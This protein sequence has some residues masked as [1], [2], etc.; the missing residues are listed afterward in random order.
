MSV[1]FS[2]KPVQE[3]VPI[4][5]GSNKPFFKNTL[6]IPGS[7]IYQKDLPSRR[8]YGA[9]RTDIDFSRSKVPEDRINF[10]KQQGLTK[11]QRFAMEFYEGKAH[12]EKLKA[13]A[14]NLSIGSQPGHHGQ[15][16]SSVGDTSVAPEYQS[17]A[18]LERRLA[19][20]PPSATGGN[21]ITSPAPRRQVNQVQ[22]LTNAISL[23]TM[24]ATATDGSTQVTSDQLPPPDR[25]TQNIPPRIR[26]ARPLPIFAAPFAP[27][28]RLD[29]E[30]LPVDVDQINRDVQQIISQFPNAQYVSQTPLFFNNTNH[31]GRMVQQSWGTDDPPSAPIQGWRAQ[32]ETAM[33]EDR[34]MSELNI[35]LQNLTMNDP[36][37]AGVEQRGTHHISTSNLERDR[38][39]SVDAPLPG[40]YPRSPTPAA[41]SPR[42]SRTPQATEPLLGVPENQS[43]APPRRWRQLDIQPV[44][45]PAMPPRGIH[46]EAPSDQ[47]PAPQALLRRSTRNRR[48]PNRLT[49]DANGNQIP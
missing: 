30:Q 6:Y 35:A 46:D 31:P 29:I 28:E 40:R 21:N 48:G 17:A 43:P 10:V 47:N 1:I 39:R 25:F 14:D 24:P 23:E 16:I 12:Y 41:I 4:V 42:I 3:P 45:A 8:L 27:I 15:P 26:D 9:G 44:Q 32:M 49:Y 18:A 37:S 2:N 34:G 19:G 36:H 5:S 7:G 33:D 20:T 22:A 13:F 11:N 38:A